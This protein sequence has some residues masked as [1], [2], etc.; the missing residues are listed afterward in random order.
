MVLKK[1]LA[2]GVVAGLKT[3]YESIVQQR[4]EVSREVEK[5]RERLDERLKRQ[6]LLNARALAFEEFLKH[7]GEL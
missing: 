6:Y 4:D 5:C 2:D 1:K 3:E 7:L